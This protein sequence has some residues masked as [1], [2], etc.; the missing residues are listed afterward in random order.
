MQKPTQMAAFDAMYQIAAADGREEALF[1]NCQPL[2]REA[3]SRSL[4]GDGFPAAWFEVPLS[5]K[6][7]FDLHVAIPREALAAILAR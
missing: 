4:A 2:A 1:G 7:R 3:F 6:P 5:G